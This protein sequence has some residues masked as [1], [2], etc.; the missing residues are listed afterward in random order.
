MKLYG[1]KEFANLLYR[2]KEPP[3]RNARLEPESDSSANLSKP[4]DPQ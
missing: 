3:R 4:F 1:Q 2:G